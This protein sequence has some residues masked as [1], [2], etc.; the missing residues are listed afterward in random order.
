[1]LKKLTLQKFL[2]QAGE[3][4]ELLQLLAASIYDYYKMHE[5]AFEDSMKEISDEWDKMREKGIIQ[6]GDE[7][8]DLLHLR[9]CRT[10]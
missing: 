9:M 10:K 6:C 1:M 7:V 5:L 3:K 4:E 2:W 8:I